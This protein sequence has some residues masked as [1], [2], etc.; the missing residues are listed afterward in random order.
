MKRT[1]AGIM[2]ILGLIAGN[3]FATALNVE[4]PES[5][6]SCGMN[7]QTYARS[8]VVVTH[9]DGTSSGFCSIHCAA[10][11]INRKGAKP[12]RDLQVADYVSS[13][14]IDART[15]T[16]VMGG[17]QR[18]V[19]TSRAKWAFA[20]A[21]EA[22]EF[23]RINGGAYATF[24]QALQDATA[25]AVKGGHVTHDH[26][27]LAFNPSFG[28]DIYHTHPAGMWMLNYRYMRMSM[29]GLRDG[30]T[31]I[32]RSAVGYKRN[33]AYNYMMIPTSM[34]MDMHMIMAMYGVTDRFTLMGMINIVDNEM[35]MLMDMGPGKMVKSDAPMKSSG[36]GDTELRGVYKVSESLNGSLGLSI[37][38]G[39]S[40]QS[41]TSMGA[42]YRAPYD[43]QLGSGTVDL[44][45]ALTLSVLSD[46]GQW[47]PGGQIMYT[48]HIGRNDN[49]YTLGDSIKLNSW[50]QR[51]FGPAAG[52]LR[53]A[54]NYSGSIKGRDPE[55]Q[56]TL[57]GMMTPS[58]PDADPN[59]YGGH[60]VDGFIGTSV[61]WHGI[62]LGVEAGIPLYQDLNGLQ[63]KNDWYLT[64]GAQFMY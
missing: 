23:I 20:N 9:E 7:R 51:A 38:T 36:L 16:W 44:K 5:C 60:R 57:D 13:R 40:T 52:W 34:T 58:M 39:N 10:T 48:H 29:N 17:S 14:L 49:G 37:P 31:D 22:E 25:E 45:P 53:L 56:R 59:N 43:M 26:G 12:I 18:G 19:M 32:P 27:P 6:E 62:S 35:Q 1:I 64:A 11:D 3:A 47:N 63:L 54:Y 8:R 21:P 4:P 15:A 41:Y 42:T 33:L 46:D 50:L 24:D 30:T 28:D 2:L 61:T 55:I